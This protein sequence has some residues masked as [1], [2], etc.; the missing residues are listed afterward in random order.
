VA[1]VTWEGLFRSCG[2]VAAALRPVIAAKACMYGLWCEKT[3]CTGVSRGA[4]YYGAP[5]RH[6]VRHFWI[7]GAAFLSVNGMRP[8]YAAE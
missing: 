8:G 3:G 6:W 2:S 5:S 7:R 1:V 4:R